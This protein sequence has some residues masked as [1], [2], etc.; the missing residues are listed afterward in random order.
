[1]LRPP[2]WGARPPGVEAHNVISAP[3]A[4]HA[5]FRKALSPAYSEKSVKEYEHVIRYYF[6]KLLT[7]L[8]KL[9]IK[10]GGSTIVDIVDWTNFATFDIIGELSWSRSYECLDKG[11]GHAFMGVLLHFQAVLI[12]AASAITHGLMRSWPALPQSRRSRCC[13]TF[14]KMDMSVYKHA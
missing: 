8:D 1:M 13:T 2:Q 4:S 3:A 7:Q 11:T 5:R 6:D 12:G 10:D 9:V 14:L